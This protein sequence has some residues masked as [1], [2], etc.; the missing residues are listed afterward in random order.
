MST[1]DAMFDVNGIYGKPSQGGADYPCVRDRLAEM[2]R[3]GVS[4][5]LLWNSDAIQNHALSSNRA[6]I[7]EI[8]RTPG[9]VGRIFPALTLSSLTL[10]ENNGMATLLDQFTAMPCRALRFTAA[11]G[12]PSLMQCAP[13]VSQLQEHK[14]FIILRHDQTSMADILEFQFQKKVLMK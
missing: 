8:A 3:L 7:D 14:P 1:I 5:A 12:H 10:Y 4:R 6:M 13:V 9:A 2:N 11:L